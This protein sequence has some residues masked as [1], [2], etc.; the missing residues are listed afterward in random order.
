MSRL[1]DQIKFHEGEVKAENGNHKVYKDHL[2]FYTVGWGHLILETD[3]ENNLEVGDEVSEE[4]VVELFENDLKICKKEIRNNLDFFDDLD[5]IRQRCI[6]D[7][8][9]NMGMPRLKKFVKTL[10][11]LKN[12]RYD[13][14]GDELL[15][16][17]YAKQVGKRAERIADM[18]KTGLES[19]D[20]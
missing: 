10:D 15:D 1:I 8:T 5:E 12:G 9:F 13:E 19:E 17:R 16:S 4:R 6:I 20:F 11:H 2:G 18:I 7:L 14:A 3:P